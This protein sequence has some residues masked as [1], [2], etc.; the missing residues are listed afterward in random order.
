MAEFSKLGYG[1]RENLDAAIDSG[2]LDE[3]DIVITKD[4]SEFIYIRDDKTQQV[5][6]SRVRTFD[7]E[8]Q[9]VS[10]LNDSSDTYAGQLVSIKDNNGTYKPFTVQKG[11]AG[12]YVEEIAMQ[13]TNTN[14]VW[15]E[16]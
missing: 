14:F 12:F 1:N 10:A 11:E 13:V 6:R 8:A 15:K 4:T 2:V 3:R 16:F 5:I 7:S 9:A